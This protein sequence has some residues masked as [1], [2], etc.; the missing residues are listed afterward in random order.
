[1]VWKGAGKQ[2]QIPVVFSQVLIE[3]WKSPD[4]LK[5]NTENE[6]APT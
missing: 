4:I 1:M 5:D 2:K 3:K 6:K